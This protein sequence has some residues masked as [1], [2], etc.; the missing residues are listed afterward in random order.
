M[1]FSGCGSGLITTKTIFFN[2]PE[3]CPAASIKPPDWYQDQRTIFFNPKTNSYN[4]GEI[5]L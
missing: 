1:G 2:S 5:I 4:P 3:F